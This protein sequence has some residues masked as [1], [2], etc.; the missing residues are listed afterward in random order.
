MWTQVGSDIVLN[1]TQ[2]CSLSSHPEQDNARLQ[3]QHQPPPQADL[4]H[5]EGSLHQGAPR[6]EGQRPSLCLKIFEKYVEDPRNIFVL[7]TLIKDLRTVL[8]EG[9]ELLT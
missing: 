9:N 3:G 7:L 4:H 2:S 5:A 6:P 8:A 1:L